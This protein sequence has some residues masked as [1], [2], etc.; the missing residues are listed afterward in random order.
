MQNKLINNEKNTF[1]INFFIEKIQEKNV[2]F[3]RF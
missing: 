2:E 1:E 3:F